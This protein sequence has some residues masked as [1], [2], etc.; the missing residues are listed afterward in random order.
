MNIKN[1]R[2]ATTVRWLKNFNLFKVCLKSFETLFKFLGKLVA[3]LLE[4]LFNT[5]GIHTFDNSLFAFGTFTI[6][7]F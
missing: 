6:D 4:E 7:G 1:H 3:K 5:A 2:T